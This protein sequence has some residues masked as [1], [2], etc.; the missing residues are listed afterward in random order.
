MDEL[1][2][3][4]VV[5]HLSFNFDEKVGLINYCQ[6]ILNPSASRV[7]RSTLTCTLFNLYKK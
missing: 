6:K 5:K 4:V 2:H 3:I 1:A 7:S